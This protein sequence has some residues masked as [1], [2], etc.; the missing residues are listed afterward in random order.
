MG[1]GFKTW[2]PIL[3]FIKLG[4][5]RK[6]SSLPSVRQRNNGTL[7]RKHFIIVRKLFIFTAAV[8][9]I[10]VSASYAQPVQQEIPSEY[11]YIV[12]L[13]QVIPDFD[14]VLPDGTILNTKD[15][16]GKVVMLQFTASWCSVC[17][18]EMPHIES[19]IWQKHKDNPAFALY[20]IDLKEPKEKV[21]GFQKEMGITYPLALDP[22]GDIFYSFA[23]RDAGVTRNVIIDKT[24]KI[25]FM[26]RLYKEE[27]FNSMKEVIA[28][29]LIDSMKKK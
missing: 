27:E 6:L 9:L 1:S 3:C 18:K 29:L 12:E 16:R 19:E 5:G 15:L 20:G 13:G 24:G 25:V 11:G 28:D 14:L 22:D 8:F 10:F 21:I 2:P 7:N 23:A 4:T 17:R 26:T